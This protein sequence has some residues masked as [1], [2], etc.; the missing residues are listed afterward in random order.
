MTEL[1][2]KKRTVQL[3]IWPSEKHTPFDPPTV[4]ILQT[5]DVTFVDGQW[6]LSGEEGD[7]PTWHGTG[8]SLNGAILDWLAA[9]L[10]L[11]DADG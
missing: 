7:G 5:V 1:A 11:K 9:R 2:S 8:D 4:G 10:G 3:I 6:Q